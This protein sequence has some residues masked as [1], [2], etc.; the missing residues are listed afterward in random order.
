MGDDNQAGMGNG[1]DFTSDREALLDVML[2]L[3]PFDGWTMTAMQEAA[4]DA[5][6][7]DEG[8][9]AD[10]LNL[11]FPKGITDI[12]DYWAV[13]ED[14]A[15]A[16]AYDA[17]DEPPARIRDKITWLVRQR[18]EQLEPHR[19]AARRAAGTLAL[20]A[21]AGV[22]PRLIWRTAGAMWV[23]LGDQSTDG[24]YYSKRATLSAVYGTT[25]TRWF[26]EAA[27]D[28][29]GEVDASGTWAFLDRRIDGVMQIEKL[30]AQ[31][32]KVSPDTDAI[33]GFL[34]RLRYGG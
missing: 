27:G 15:M 23:A 19:E 18:I 7:A 5:G 34:G 17:L 4:K 25:L 2:G 9:E 1:P 14:A 29:F 20:P 21:F 16:A 8:A 30:K 22:G 31:A 10:R 3:V 6:I 13:R 11:L 28:G 24:N 33:V 32:R 12:L 26:A